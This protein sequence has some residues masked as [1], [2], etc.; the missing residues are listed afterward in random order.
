MRF[1]CHKGS[2]T[3]PGALFPVRPRPPAFTL[4]ELL[5]VIAIIAI[6]AGMLLPALSRAREKALRISCLNN[7]KQMGYGCIMYSDEDRE[8]RFT[9][10]TSY[11]D[12]DINFLYPKFVPSVRTYICPSTRNVVRT[13]R[14]FD[15]RLGQYTSLIDLQDVAPNR[16]TNGYSYEIYAFMR[17]IGTETAGA[18]PKTSH[19]VQT[20]ARHNASSGFG[21]QKGEVPGPANIWI[22]IDA[23]EGGKYG[24]VARG[25]N[26]RPDVWDNHRGDG[27]NAVFCD[28]HAEWIPGKQFRRRLELSQDLGNSD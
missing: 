13:N 26:D 12:D 28:G 4:I 2:G 24:G 19:N 7:V 16:D 25:L 6:L 5:V 10:L 14:L 11:L 20:Y 22:F 23:D 3:G 17:V 18:V 8:G 9:P 21:F 27:Y 1:H 15:R